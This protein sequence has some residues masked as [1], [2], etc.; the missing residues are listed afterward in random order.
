MYLPRYSK[1][2]PFWQLRIIS[3]NG[4]HEKYVQASGGID[5]FQVCTDI[6]KHASAYRSTG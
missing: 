4:T 2:G 3:F 1:I 6:R 5:T